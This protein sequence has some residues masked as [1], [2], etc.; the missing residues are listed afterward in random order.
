MR[1]ACVLMIGIAICATTPARGDEIIFKNGDHLSGKIVGA[2]GGK[3][4]V[5]TSVA[6]EIKVDMK[7][8][9]S[10][11]TEEPIELR[12]NDGSTIKDR[13]TASDEGTIATSG[14]GTISVQTVALADVKKINPPPVKWSGALTAGGTLTRGNSQTDDLH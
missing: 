10:F 2:D 1:F 8:V 5:K 14:E 3:L 4:T 9:K 7:D 13:V 11:S 6:G 12:L